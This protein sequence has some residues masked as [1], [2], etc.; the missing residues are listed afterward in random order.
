MAISESTKILSEHESAFSLENAPTGYEPSESEEKTIKM[1]DRLFQ[2]SKNAKKAY[3]EKWLDYYRMFRGKQW[4]DARPSY[5]HSEVINLVFRAIQSE[6]PILT[7]GLP[8]PE[9]LP[10]EPNDFELAQILNDVLDS[11]WTANNWAYKFTEA[12]YDSHIYGNGFGCLKWD[13][14]LLDGMGG[15]DF[16]SADPFYQFPD[17]YS[18]DVNEKSRYYIEAEPVDIEVLKQRYPEKAQFIKADIVDITKRDK[19]VSEQVR[20]KS[21]T[22]NRTVLEGSSSYDLES[23]NEALEVCCYVKDMEETEE[24]TESINQETG[25][26]SKLYVKKLKYPNG[27]KIV[28]IN[29]VLCSDEPIPYDDQKFPYIRLTNY[30]L[31]REF[32]GISEVEQLESPQKI[33]NKLVSFALD[34]LTLMGN[35][36]W[37]VDN[38]SGID[39]DNLFNRPGLIVEKEPNSEVRR[40]EGV[41]LQ[42]YVLQMIDR[43][44]GWFDDIS[45]SNDVSRGVRPEGITAASAITALQDAAQTRLRQ[46]TRNID[47]FMQNFGQMY[48]SRVFQYYTAPRVFRITDNQNSSKYFKFHVD[49]T[50][51]PNTGEAVKVAKVRRYNQGDDKKYYLGAEQQ[52]EIRQRFDVKIAT[53]SALPFEKSRIESQSF[54]LF[55]RGIIDAEEVLKNIRYPNS[56][57]VMKRM[58]EKA[59]QQAQMQP[60]PSSP[61]QQTG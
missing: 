27:R 59:M 19:Q 38:T 9:F 47:T 25:E 18:M 49:Q 21:P 8:K 54:N 32:W 26:I 48:I 60:P 4:K 10:V 45:G 43:M 33:F 2:R 23:R 35:P 53:G 16:H 11:D 14:D 28:V 39:T 24:E 31:P 44:K 12:L 40:E 1:V 22:D 34:V 52:F 29:G 5:R 42:P 51:D 41:Q 15:I 30:I 46:K 61:T 7:D 37:I 56:E 13:A 3:D 36:I 58:Q 17:P 50:I 55:D 20:Y 57:S 6:V